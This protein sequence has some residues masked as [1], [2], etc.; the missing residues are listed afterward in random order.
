MIQLLLW[1]YSDISGVN[2]VYQPCNSQ[3]IVIWN[4]KEEEIIH[5][6]PTFPKTFRVPFR[7]IYITCLT[8]SLWIIV[9]IT[10]QTAYPHPSDCHAMEPPAKVS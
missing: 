2:F 8:C 3:F 6:L 9:E 5:K 4:E 7:G 1:M 10:L